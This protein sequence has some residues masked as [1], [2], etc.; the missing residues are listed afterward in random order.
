[1][2]VVKFVSWYHG[3]PFLC[4]V[5]VTLLWLGRT[6]GQPMLRL[7]LILK[8]DW[9]LANRSSPPEVALERSTGWL[10]FKIRTALKPLPQPEALCHPSRL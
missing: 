1:M 7:F 5:G 2:R 3:G 9:A 10:G 6:P 8:P 4:I